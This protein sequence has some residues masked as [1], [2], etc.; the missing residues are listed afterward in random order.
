MKSYIK[1]IDKCPYVL[2]IVL[3]AIWVPNFL[4]R[5]FYIIDTKNKVP[6]TLVYLILTVIPFISTILYICDI[7]KSASHK[8]PPK[9]IRELLTK[10]YRNKAN[11][12]GKPKYQ[13]AKDYKDVETVDAVPVDED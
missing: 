6:G 1:F 8:Y 3:S 10:N 12:E 11:K 2:S 13:K 9:T 5:L 4:Y 7:C